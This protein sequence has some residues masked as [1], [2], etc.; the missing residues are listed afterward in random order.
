MDQQ[1]TLLLGESLIVNIISKKAGS[2]QILEAT[3]GFAPANRGFADRSL[4]LLGYV[5]KITTWFT[6]RSFSEG[7]RRRPIHERY[8]TTKGSTLKG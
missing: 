4:G 5:A 1:K 7:R 3:A 8:F 2:C 6:G